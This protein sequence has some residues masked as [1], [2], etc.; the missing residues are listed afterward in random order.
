MMLVLLLLNLNVGG[1]L[2]VL[3]RGVGVMLFGTL[4]VMVGAPI[5][6]WLVKGWLDPEAWKAFGVLAGSWIG[7]TGNMAAVSEMIDAGGTEFGLAVIGDATIYLLWLPI[8]LGSKRFATRFT[9]Y[10]G[11]QPDRLERMKTAASAE[12]TES[13][14]PSTADFLSLLC[15]ALLATWVAEI[16]AGR[17][18]E[19]QPY[20]DA[21]AWKMLLITAIGIGLSFTSLRKIPGSHELGMALV[22][23]FVALMGAT[24]EL[25]SIIAQLRSEKL[26]ILRQSFGST[27]EIGLDLLR[28][29][30][31]C[32]FLTGWCDYAGLSLHQVDRQH[33]KRCHPQQDSARKESQHGVLS[34]R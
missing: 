14:A 19:F 21:K 34:F 25:S 32:I 9:A 29:F 7:G 8:L 17:L 27:D 5:G 3:G 6:L 1:A 22:Y 30:R 24:A 16:A 33:A 2:R 26:N 20:L 12:R 11:V 10:T 4:G 28:E 13:K 15:V 31:Q 23:L 18:P